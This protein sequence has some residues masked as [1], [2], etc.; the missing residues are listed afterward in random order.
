MSE[1]PAYGIG[2]MQGRLV[3]PVDGRVQAFP[4]ERWEDEFP[5]AQRLGFQSM[6]LTIELASWDIHPIRSDSG[7]QRLRRLSEEHGIALAGLCCDAV[8][9]RPL[10]DPDPEIR[11]TAG[12]MLSGL[13]E[14]AAQLGL[15]MI[16]LPVMGDASLRVPEARARFSEAMARLLPVA[17]ATEVDILLESDLAPGKLRA[18]VEG[19]ASRRIGIN[20][21]TGNST[22][23]GFDADEEL[24]ILMPHVRNVHIK[25]CTRADYSVPLGQGETR[26][27]RVFRHLAEAGY[28]GGFILQPAR[29]ADDVA[30]ARDYLAFTRNLVGTLKASEPV[31]MH[32][33]TS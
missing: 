26:F 19:F 15:P 1:A 21:D 18:L 5:I 20:Y 9:E 8:M 17:E 31:L 12:S 10:S 11:R 16:E 24:P 6:E 32:A 29:Q 28:R 30:A 14:D 27:D 33:E 22:W 2:I 25:D 4:A 7:Q 23:F 13:I 3:P